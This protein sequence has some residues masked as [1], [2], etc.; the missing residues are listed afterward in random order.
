MSSTA[1]EQARAAWD[2]LAVHADV[3]VESRTSAQQM[4]WLQCI[5]TLERCLPALR[6]EAINE[7]AEHATVAEV[8]GSVRTALADALRITPAEAARRI[9]EAADLGPRRT[10]T[11]E[12]LLPR[13]QATAAGQAAGE[14]SS[15]HVDE[16]RGFFAR[17]PHFVDESAKVWAEAKLA[18]IAAAYRPDQLIKFAQHLDLILNPD[19]NFSDADRAR[20]RGLKLGP[21]RPDGTSRI[22]GD[23]T[24]ELRASLEAAFAKW[25]APGMCNLADEQ[26]TV[27]GEPC[28]EAKAGDVRSAAM[29]NHDALAMMARSTLMSG[30]LGSH[31]GLPVTIVA[32]AKLEDLQAK[33]GTATT[34]TGTA[35][36][37]TDVI[38]MGGQAYNFLLLFDNPKRCRLYRGRDTR[39]A[40]PA[41][42]LVLFATERGCTRPGCTVPGA[43]CQV[44]HVNK[45]WAKGGPTDID[46]LTLSCGPDNRL[47]NDGWTTR[48][49]K[50][51]TTEWIPPP[52]LDT[53]QRRFNT[54]FHPERMLRDET[55][56]DEAE[57]A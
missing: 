22:S 40:T 31:Q 25:A 32:I 26:P 36:P 51:G 15:A 34:A 21:Q 48:K 46:N 11:G 57:S 44:H 49:L 53:G 42:R 4:R 17:L 35:L 14:I 6:H 27:D 38:R 52:D 37:I 43:W 12:P 1:F 16:I 45:D 19:G 28:D 2:E 30:D 41:Q 39:L 50:D 33:T 20:R 8:G 55:G 10:L 5:E 56:G 24:P 29:R 47:V 54:Y 23:V 13:L 18:E 7:L 9:E 3:P